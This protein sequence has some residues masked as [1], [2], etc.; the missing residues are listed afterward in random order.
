[1]I[2]TFIFDFDGTLID[3]LPTI[4]RAV[5]SVI[6]ELKLPA[7]S[8][9]NVKALMGMSFEASFT[10]A[11]PDHLDKLEE[12]R[13]L[14]DKIVLSKLKQDK[15]FKSTLK[16]LDAIRQRNF[17]I[18]IAT[19]NSRRILGILLSHY[20]IEVDA[21]V[22]SDDTKE[23]RPNPKPL[24]LALKMLGSRPENALYVGD[25]PLDAV[26]GK[27]AGIK[28]CILLTSHKKEDFETAPDYFFENIDDLL[29]IVEAI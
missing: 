1:M 2:D 17:K 9:E 8:K 6:R 5:E 16:I 11:Y 19:T 14:Y 26:Q 20:K 3:S 21:L 29:T 22:A 7:I 10:K 27:N 25:D 28:T 13:G 15:L 24:L 12:A 23:T 4:Y 18:G